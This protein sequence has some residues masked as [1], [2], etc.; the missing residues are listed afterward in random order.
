MVFLLKKKVFLLIIISS[1][2]TLIA[3]EC[4]D[5]YCAYYTFINK[6]EHK[7]SLY[8]YRTQMV[9]EESVELQG[10]DTFKLKQPYCNI[11]GADFPFSFIYSDSVILIINDTLR[12]ELMGINVKRN[13]SI[14]GEKS[15]L[16]NESYNVVKTKKNIYY[17]EYEFTDWHYQKALE[18]NG[19]K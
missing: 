7:I 15:P 16:L 14:Y 1:F 17:S 19:Y 3:S 8:P 4:E 2:F 12:V 6:T 10:I 5:E 9:V 11:G 18:A 13:E